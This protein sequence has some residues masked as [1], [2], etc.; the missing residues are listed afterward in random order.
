MLPL[1]SCN[2][3]TEKTTLLQID[4]FV[5]D[6]DVEKL[7]RQCLDE[8]VRPVKFLAWKKI[9]YKIALSFMLEGRRVT[10]FSRHQLRILG[11]YRKVRKIWPLLDI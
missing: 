5:E 11:P 7:I 1:K 9:W 8:G 4:L 3:G 6:H 10:L 2:R